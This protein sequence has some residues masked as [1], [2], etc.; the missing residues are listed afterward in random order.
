MYLFDP[1]AA[2]EAGLTLTVVDGMFVLFMREIYLTEVVA[3]AGVA[4]L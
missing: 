2:F 4:V 3:I 1:N